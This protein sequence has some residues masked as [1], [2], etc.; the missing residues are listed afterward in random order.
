MTYD[1]IVIGAGPGGY[2]AAARALRAGWRVLVVEAGHPGGTCLNRGCIPTKVMARTAD[3]ALEVASAPAFGVEAQGGNVDIRRVMERK[4]EVVGQLREA[5]SALIAGAD[6]ITGTA[7]FTALG[8]IEVNGGRHTAPRIV[9]ATGAT[10]AAL[11]IPGAELC[12]TSDQVLDWQ[13]LPPSVVIIGAGVIGMEFASILN[14]YGVDVT[15]V[16]YAKEIL[17]GF[18]EDIAKRLRSTLKAR[19][20]KITTQANVQAV[21]KT[22]GGTPGTLTVS[23]L[24]KKGK[25]E[26]ATA[27]RVIMC[28]GRKAVVPPG[29]EE[30]GGAVGRRG[31]E[32]DAN[33]AATI[34]GVYAI[35]DCNGIC[36]LAHV[37]SAQAGYLMDHLLGLPASQTLTPVPAAVFTVPEIAMVGL[38]EEQAPEGATIRRIPLA[39]NGKALCMGATQGMVKTVTGPDGRLLGCHIIGP[40]A[41]DLIMEAT[42]AIAAGLPASTLRSIIHPHPTLSE[43][44]HSAL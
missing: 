17:P 18:D 33:F 9:I 27:S 6:C 42:I 8:E 10:P 25:E 35:G 32:V 30:H 3:V 23:Y 12:D 34:P 41:S 5:V 40:H 15:V 2:P 38:T 22:E 31:I 28:V 36:Q 14:A 13:S 19:G 7:R 11:P 37:A 26:S 21:S 1:L 16:E 44:L 39:S 20:V 43:L 4:A 29:F 24:N